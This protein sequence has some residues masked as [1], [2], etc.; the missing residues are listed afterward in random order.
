VGN[1]VGV[2]E[3]V[4]H[5]HLRVVHVLHRAGEAADVKGA[6]HRLARLALDIG[7]LTGYSQYL[8]DPEVTTAASRTLT[9][10]PVAVPVT[11]RCRCSLTLPLN[12]VA[13]TA[14]RD[15][16]ISTSRFPG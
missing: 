6:K 11:C 14:D 5:G 10:A 3:G 4:G 13:A 8:N 7:C 9:A 15:I 12:T 16:R 2:G 1:E